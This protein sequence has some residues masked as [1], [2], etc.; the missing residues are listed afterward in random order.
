MHHTDDN[1]AGRTVWRHAFRH[2]HD[3]HRTGRLYDRPVPR[4][5]YIRPDTEVDPSLLHVT[6]DR[7][8]ARLAKQV[9]VYAS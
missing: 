2:T 9:L 8:L 4:T 3:D 6:E 7:V 1:R 5:D